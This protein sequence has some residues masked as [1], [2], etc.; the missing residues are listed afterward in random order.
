M[1]RLSLLLILA[2]LLQLYRASALL[3]GEHR[4]RSWAVQITDGENETAKKIA[5]RNG[6][7]NRGKVIITQLIALIFI[8]MQLIKIINFIDASGGFRCVRV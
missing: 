3:K 8:C 7:R 1:A 2:A 5:E 4:T 6:F